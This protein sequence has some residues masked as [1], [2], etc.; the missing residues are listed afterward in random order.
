SFAL[1]SSM[2]IVNITTALILDAFINGNHSSLSS[3]VWSITFELLLFR[4]VCGCAEFKAG[5]KRLRKQATKT[6]KK[7]SASA[8]SNEKADDRSSKPA[9]LGSPSSSLELPVLPLSPSP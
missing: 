6:E 4:N 2:A 9:L 1:T 3:F 7:T 8:S 5:K